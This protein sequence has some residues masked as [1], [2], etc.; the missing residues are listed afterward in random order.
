MADLAFG[1]QIRLAL[2]SQKYISL[3]LLSD[4]EFFKTL[5]HIT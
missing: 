3:Y 5:G 2:N 4:E 1:M